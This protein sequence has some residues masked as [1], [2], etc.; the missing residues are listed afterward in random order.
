MMSLLLCYRTKVTGESDESV[1]K[2]GS[3]MFAEQFY[4][5]KWKTQDYIRKSDDVI[6]GTIEDGR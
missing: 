3:M 1:V 4:C 6:P 2:N 5:K